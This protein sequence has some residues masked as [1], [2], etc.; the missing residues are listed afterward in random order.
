MWKRAS[1]PLPGSV[2][3]TEQTG[4][5]ALTARALG[6]DL[7]RGFMLLFIAL[8]NSHYFLTR[9]VGA[10]RLPA[11]R[12]GRRLGGDVADL[13]LRRRPGVPDVRPALRLRRRADRPPPRA[14]R[15]RGPCA[16][17]CG[18]AA[19]SWSWSASCTRCCSTSATSS[20]RTACC[21]CSACG[22]CAGRTVGCCIVAP[23]FFAAHRAA[24]RR[25][26]RPS[27]AGRRTADA[28][29]R[30][31]RRCSPSGSRCSRSSCCSADRLRLPVPG[32]TVGGA[33]PGARAARAAPAAARHHGRRR[34]RRRRCSARSRSP[35]CW[36][37]WR[38][39]P[40]RRHARR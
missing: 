6:P 37:A 27:A 39:V 35:A 3:T 14:R 36:R 7:A 1:R 9:P 25:L 32:R 38:A 40:G 15:Q 22:R 33:A 24:E 26:A 4:A 31:A 12:L 18:G 34:H 5:T 13:D 23:L 10:R 21:S 2:T 19:W 30:H 17:C 16:G 8:A 29:H 20:R 11:G 28:A